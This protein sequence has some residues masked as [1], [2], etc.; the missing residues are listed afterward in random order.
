[1]EG[2][3]WLSLFLFSAHNRDPLAIRFS[4]SE[5]KEEEGEETGSMWSS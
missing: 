4:L 3:V 2:M 5:E 1:M